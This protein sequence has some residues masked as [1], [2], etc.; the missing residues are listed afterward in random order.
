MV[1]ADRVVRLRQAGRPVEE[2]AVQGVRKRL[3]ES[4]GGVGRRS[5]VA[6]V[7]HRGSTLSVNL[8]VIHPTAH[9]GRVRVELRP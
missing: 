5:G 6:D 7:C 4:P 8:L 2:L 1:A 9:D 3:R